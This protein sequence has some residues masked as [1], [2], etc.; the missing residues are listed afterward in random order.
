MANYCGKCGTLVV[1]GDRFCRQCG[2]STPLLPGQ[3]VPRTQKLPGRLHRLCISG[4]FVWTAAWASLTVRYFT[5]VSDA[6][7]RSDGAALGLGLGLG[8][9]GFFWFLPSMVLGIIAVATKPTPAVPWPR[10]TRVVTSTV[11]A[12]ILLFPLVGRPTGGTAD[13]ERH[14]S[15][16]SSQG[17]LH[18]VRY[19]VDAG[20]P[21]FKIIFPSRANLTYRNET[22]GTEQTSVAVRWELK[23]QCPAGFIPYIAAQ[24]GE[25]P[26]DHVPMTDK[27]GLWHNKAI[28]VA[29]YVD[30]RLVQQAESSAPY[31][32]ASASGEVYP[33]QQ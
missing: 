21:E 23:M 11:V 7:S 26:W 15:T 9:Y 8:M 6:A 1:D 30:G 10:S 12:T 24:K 4:L 22:G 32:V 27:S 14:S 13:E 28:H 3:G 19:V 2:A 5:L 16:A 33:L 18:E 25:E 31:G 20:E 17:R 29:V